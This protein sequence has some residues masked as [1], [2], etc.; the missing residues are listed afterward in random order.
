[1]LLKFSYLILLLWL[2]NIFFMNGFFFFDSKFLRI[3]FAKFLR[4]PFKIFMFYVLIVRFYKVR[5]KL[6]SNWT[7]IQML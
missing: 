1:M 7:I 3:R 6:Q 5:K 4:T 2:F